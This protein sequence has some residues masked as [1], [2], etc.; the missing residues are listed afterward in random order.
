VCPYFEQIHFS[1][2]T[3]QPPRR[4]QGSTYGVAGSP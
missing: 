4:I 1:S 3:Q 2:L